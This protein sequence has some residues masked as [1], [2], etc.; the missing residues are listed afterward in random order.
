M[1]FLWM[2]R[3]KDDSRER[4]HFGPPSLDVVQKRDYLKYVFASYK[5]KLMLYFLISTEQSTIQKKK[6]FPNTAANIQP[7]CLSKR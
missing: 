3:S 4:A 1:E 2:E 7:L 5:L 6:T